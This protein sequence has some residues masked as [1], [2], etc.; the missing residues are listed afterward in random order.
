MFYHS[1]GVSA[2]NC[3]HLL[4]A[5][6]LSGALY[7][8]A[9]HATPPPVPPTEKVGLQKNGSVVLPD[10]QVIE[11]AG[12]QITVIGRPSVIAIR[13]DHKTAVVINGDGNTGFSAGPIVIFDLVKGTV[14]QQLKPF[15]GAEPS[16]TGAVYSPDGQHLYASDYANNAT[17]DVYQVA[18]DGTVTYSTSVNLPTPNGNNSIPA[19]L[20]ISPD[21]NTIYAALNGLN[22]VAVIDVSSLQVTAQIP[23]GNAPWGVALDTTNNIVW[24]TNEGGLVP[25]GNDPTNSSDGTNI[26]ANPA[27]GAASTGS[28]SGVD[29]ASGTVKYTIQVGL[30]P[31]AV[32]LHDNMLFV[33]NTNSDTI[34]IIDPKAGTLV[35]TFPLFPGVAY[36]SQP[37]DINFL[38]D[39]TFIVS[40]GGNNALALY[41]FASGGWAV[42]PT[43]DGLIPTGWYPGFIAVDNVHNQILVSNVRGIGLEGPD[44]SKGPDSATNKTGPAEISTY[45]VVL[46]I[47]IPNAQ[48]LAAYTAT[49]L[50][51]NSFLKGQVTDASTPADTSNPIPTTL[52]QSSPIKHVF[53]ILKENRTYDQILGDDARG[54]GDRKYTQFGKKVTPNIHALANQYALL[55]NYY[56]PSLN[57]ADGH[58]WANQALAPDYLE[59]ELN[60]NARSY[61]SAGGDAMAYASSGFLWQ[62]LVNQR[63]T[64]RVYGE[65]AYEGNGP[66]NLYG[67]W[68][69]W[70]NDSLILEGKK[71]GQLHC[72]L[73]TF[74]GVSD[75]PIIQNNLDIDF[76]PFDTEIPDQYRVDVFLLEFNQYVANNNLPSLV[77]LWLCDDHTSGISVGFPTPAAQVADNDLAVG[78]VVDAISHS[79]YWKD[80]AIFITEDD[81]QDGVDHVDGHRTEG[82]VISPFVKRNIVDSTYYNQLSIIRTIEQILGLPPMNQH[83]LVTPPMTGLFTNTPNYTP[84]TA[85]KN[86]IPLNRLTTQQT[87]SRTSKVQLA[88]QQES[89]KMFARPQRADSADP[90]ILNHAI[91]YATKGFNTP[92]PGEKTV[93][94]PSEVKRSPYRNTY[95]D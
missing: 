45:S 89:A 50:K 92:Y 43:L 76:P 35:Y 16:L 64:L 66:N 21:G 90:N 48:Q 14:L 11:P 25:T 83:D 7:S 60:T 17:I 34:S 4:L 82:L 9:L 42:P 63:G 73:G 15:S 6:L 78:R 95:D 58:Q 47:D 2:K 67:D 69:S 75:V 30:E 51:N 52:G 59:K 46:Q 91:W 22:E 37:N 41:T 40:L 32:V 10:S 94:F 12:N 44:I 24:V 26:L 81:A 93:L 29:L 18:T 5:S 72:P 20:A 71:T 13:P 36:G 61:P 38:P 88:W 79:P 39:G 65:Y 84:Y 86:N 70:Y 77:Y 31:T 3:R 68:T 28:V 55:D 56:A 54:N 27:T 1:L 33:A 62:N 87:A 80:S 85:L 49:V 8:P 19:G 57:S 74:P 53:Y 23:V